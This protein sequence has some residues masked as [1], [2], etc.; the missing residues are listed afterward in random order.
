MGS[1]N[2]LRL[3]IRKHG[4]ENF[5]REILEFFDTREELGNREEEIVNLDE[6][7]KVDCMNLTVGGEGGYSKK[8]NDAYIFKL[9]NDK[10]FRERISKRA[11]E[12]S[13][14]LHKEGKLKNHKDNG[15]SWVGK[16]HS[17]ETKKKISESKKDE[18]L[19]KANSQYGTCWITRDGENKKIPKEQLNY[20]IIEEGWLKGRKIKKKK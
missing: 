6:I 15:W 1:G 12:N 7:A 10:G 11:T 3:A 5:S 9:N 13:I 20:M 16:T 2:R 8:G 18:G 14:R 19:G 4:K 17:E